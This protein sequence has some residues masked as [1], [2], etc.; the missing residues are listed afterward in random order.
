MTRAI[1]PM[2]LKDA[3]SVLADPDAGVVPVAGATDLLVIDRAS[4]RDHRAV[5]DLLRIPELLG[6]HCENG[7]LD[8]GAACT[9]R[10]IRRDADVRANAPAL[11]EAAA[12]IGSWQIQNRATIGGNM[13]NAS[14][15]GD[16]LPVLLALDAEVTIAGAGGTHTFPYADFHTGYR[17]T[18]LRPGELVQR[19]RIPFP[20]RGTVQRFRKVGTRQAQAISK[21]VISFAAR[22]ERGVFAQVRFAAG[23]VAPTPVRLPRAEEAC[24]GHPIDRATADRAAEAARSE[25]QPIDDV[26]STAAYRRFV[27]GRVVRRMILDYRRSLDGS[28]D[29]A[30]GSIP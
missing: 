9:F 10:E 13:V 25:V 30:G 28:T 19:I 15:A 23:S 6:I 16:S 20:P 1:R 17:K 22:A 24:R 26:R 4:G 12:T 5:M 8:I 7:F 2:S 29:T 27:L 14:P 11:A 18:A 3:L 21:V